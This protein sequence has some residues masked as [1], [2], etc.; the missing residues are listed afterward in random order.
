M[1]IWQIPNHLEDRKGVLHISGANA[2]E[3][4]DRYGTP[5]FVFSEARIRQNIAEV[6][7]AFERPG[8]SVRICYASKANGN[9]AVLETV[10]ASGIDI[11][12]NSGGELYKALKV[13]FQPAQI[14]FNGVAKTERE[15]EEAIQQGIACINV[16]SAFELGRIIA[17]A[18]RLHKRAKIALR[19]APEVTTGSH[20]GLETGTSLSKFGIAED[21]ID[22]VWRDALKHPEQVAL[23]GLHMHIGA[24][25]SN[26][27]KHG[28]GLRAMLAI[29]ARLFAD[30]RH[31]IEPLNLGGGL[32]VQFIKPEDDGAAPTDSYAMLKAGPTPADVAQATLG[33]LDRYLDEWSGSEHAEFRQMIHDAQ[34]IIEPGSR[35]IADTAV[36]LTRVQN[37]KTRHASEITWL[38]LDAGFNTLADILGYNWYFH[39]I[40]AEKTGSPADYPYKLAGPLC[41]SGDTYHDSEGYRRLPDFHS[42]PA[43]MKPGAMIAFLDVAG[44]TL[45]QMNQYNGQRR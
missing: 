13:G 8:A 41:D 30:T 1:T 35:I 34:F 18:S 6:R 29:A 21:K 26:A 44:Y 31:R 24:E 17:I 25:V 11:E 7:A 32:P 42:L 28:E 19:I 33:S 39:P 14:V 27:E 3:L 40:A 20:G 37:F 43:D 36:L 5:L 2:R 23:I 4:A 15:L 22:E 12:V 16:D 10:K 45:E 38:M 9:L